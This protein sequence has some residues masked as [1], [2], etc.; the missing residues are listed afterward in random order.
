M[1]Q[2]LQHRNK[3]CLAFHRFQRFFSFEA[4]TIS[5][6]RTNLIQHPPT[7]MGRYLFSFLQD[8][9]IHAPNVAR[10]NYWEN[11]KRQM[12]PRLLSTAQKHNPPTPPEGVCLVPSADDQYNAGK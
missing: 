9:G 5:P 10:S 6:A 11:D 1:L 12:H 4:K 2:V 3:L 8:G 7:V